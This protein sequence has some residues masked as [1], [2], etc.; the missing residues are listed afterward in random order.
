MSA[1][2]VN[3]Y[4]IAYQFLD[5]ELG[6]E[7]SEEIRKRFTSERGP[8]LCGGHLVDVSLGTKE[9]KFGCKDWAG[10]ETLCS[11]LGLPFIQKKEKQA[12]EQNSKG[13]FDEISV[14]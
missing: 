10:I 4:S 11:G 13:W 14:R 2:N 6:S 3:Y 5:N 8:G 1:N 7:T 12:W 9:V